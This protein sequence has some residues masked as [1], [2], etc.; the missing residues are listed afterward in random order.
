[1]DGCYFITSAHTSS[2]IVLCFMTCCCCCTPPAT[3]VSLPRTCSHFFWFLSTL[4]RKAQQP[5]GLCDAQIHPLGTHDPAFFKVLWITLEASSQQSVQGA[6]VCTCLMKKEGRFIF[7]WACI[8]ETHKKYISEFSKE[9][10][11]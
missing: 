9:N 3:S 10:L 11:K 6:L 2:P 8:D 4:L 5:Y 1:M 7:F